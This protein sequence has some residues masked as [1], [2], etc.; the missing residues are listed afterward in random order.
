M[1]LAD[2]L[3]QTDTTR[4]K[5]G[6]KPGMIQLL[7]ALDDKGRE[8]LEHLIKNESFSNS[9]ISDILKDESEELEELAK[10]EKDADERRRIQDLAKLHVISAFTIGR[11]RRQVRA[12]RYGVY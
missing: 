8:A 7:E 9:M 6:P 11:F 1:S 3:E 2:R 4:H 12:G 10:K 5:P